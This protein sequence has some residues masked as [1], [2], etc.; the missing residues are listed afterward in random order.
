MAKPS[1][2]DKRRARSAAP[3]LMSA[4]RPGPVPASASPL[5]SERHLLV[6]DI[7]D[8][9]HPGSGRGRG[10]Q[11]DAVA[12]R[13]EDGLPFLSG[14]HLRGLL[15]E[16]LGCL[17]AWGHVKD[18][19]IEERLFGPARGEAATSAAAPT[20]R[21]LDLARAELPAEDRAALLAAKAVDALYQGRF[22]I[23]MDGAH[24]VTRQGSLRS[25]EI[26][27]PMTLVAPLTLRSSSPEQAQR[28]TKALMQ[29]IDLV[30]AVGAQR[31]RG[32][33][34]ARLRL[35]AWR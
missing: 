21:C 29:A 11:Y 14:T 16:A 12:R 32:L 25:L 8:A 26:V 5:Q 2:H 30:H 18:P 7:L 6:V 33:G 35:E 20:G 28:D 24:G 1:R 23:A 4:P 17:V 19:A 31:N 13:D 34:R 22:Q 9:W 10:L 27:V 3:A 15:R